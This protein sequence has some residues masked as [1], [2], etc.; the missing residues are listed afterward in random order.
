M[1]LCMKDLILYLRRDDDDHSAR[2]LLGQAQVLGRDLLPLF[3]YNHKEPKLWDLG[4]RLLVNLTHPALLLYDEEVP[5]NKKY[6]NYYNQLLG[7]L[8]T[9][10]EDFVDKVVWKILAEKLRQ[11]LNLEWDKRMEHDRITIERILIVIRNILHVPADPSEE[12]RADDDTSLHDRIL[13]VMHISGFEDLLL[14]AAVSE[15]TQEFSVLILEIM[16]WMLREQTGEQLAKTQLARN[17][18]DKI[19][20]ER[21]LVRM[22]EKEAVLKTIQLQKLPTRHSRFGG[23]FVVRDM[24]APS[25][26][27]LLCHKP[28]TSV[29]DLSLDSTKKRKRVASNRKPINDEDST[30]RSTIPIRIILK[31][32]C[33]SFL[34]DGTYNQMMSFVKDGIV[35]G[36][37]EDNDETYYLW[38]MKFFMEFNRHHQFSVSY[39]SETMSTSTF[40]YVQT[41]LD[42]YQGMMVTDKEKIPFWSRRAH[43]ALKAYQEL[44][45]SLLWMDRDEDES[46]KESSRVI[47][48]NVFYLPEY[49]ELCHGLLNT[50]DPVKLSK[51]YLKDLIETNHLFLKMLEDYS[52]QNRRIMIKGKGKRKKSTKVSNDRILIDEVLYYCTTVVVEDRDNSIIL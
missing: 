35:R 43:M 20:D 17:E 50:Y 1:Y 21:E 3:K 11:L 15:T 37:T 23:T 32:F 33:T 31:D 30:R 12:R 28:I 22:R 38:G 45:F 34:V 8:R 9:Y 36:R 41:L 49:R 27:D 24:K 39:V 5:K 47:K 10:K 51:L 52:S 46:V 40:H 7:Y 6:L 13:M 48:S 2:R 25:G 26:R 16:S 29:T 44:L 18:D 19:K 14:Y 4:L 42:R